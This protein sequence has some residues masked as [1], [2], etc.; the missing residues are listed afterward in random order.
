MAGYQ[1]VLSEEASRL[2]AQLSRAKQR[3]VGAVLDD[4]KLSPFRP[5]DFHQRDPA[6]R[7]NEVILLGDWL[8][9]YWT[10]HAVK[11]IRVVALEPADEN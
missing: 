9:T 6:G 8:V 11:E 4:V 7:I 10:D 1:L 3:Q 2:F 5:G